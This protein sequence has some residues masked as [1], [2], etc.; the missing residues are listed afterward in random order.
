MSEPQPPDTASTV[1]RRVALTVW[2]TVVWCALWE[3]IRPGV[4]LAGLAIGVG[5]SSL[6]RLGSKEP[7]STL[8]PLAALRFV[9]WFAW[10][11]ITST[12][13]VVVQVLRPGPPPPE[14]IVAVPIRGCS[15]TVITIVGHAIS[16]TP[17]TITIEARRGDPPMLYVHVLG[18]EDLEATRHDI[19]AL[20]ARVIRAFGPAEAV[21]ELDDPPPNLPTRPGPR[22]EEAA[23]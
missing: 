20:E 21:A 22:D 4:V 19:L 15:D 2:L 1:T 11:L 9:A 8:R 14:G 6:V 18:L 7:P 23:P 17:G 5:V 10:A 3:D 16:L 12:G 13:R